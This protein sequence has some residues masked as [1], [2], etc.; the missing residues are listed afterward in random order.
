MIGWENGVT[1]KQDVTKS[2]LQSRYGGIMKRVVLSMCVIAGLPFLVAGIGSCSKEVPVV[3]ELELKEVQLRL[4]LAPGDSVRLRKTQEMD[5]TTECRRP[6]R[7]TYTINLEYALRCL[8]RDEDGVM[9]IKQTW[10]SA[11]AE[12]EGVEGKFEWHSD[13]DIRPVPVEVRRYAALVGKSIQAKV[14]PRGNV[15]ELWGGEVVADAML[16]EW[17]PREHSGMSE[18]KYESHRQAY[19][20]RLLQSQEYILDGLL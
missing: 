20:T 17:D 9:L 1:G 8:E 16:A 3:P 7:M 5:V 11:W 10:V 18:E 4:S 12:G 2:V 15:L 14:N 6:K 19:S 13:R